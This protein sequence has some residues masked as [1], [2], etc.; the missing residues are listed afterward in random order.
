MPLARMVGTLTATINLA[1]PEL[2]RAPWPRSPPKTKQSGGAPQATTGKNRWGTLQVQPWSLAQLHRICGAQWSVPGQAK[3]WWWPLPEV[4]KDEG[5]TNKERESST[6]SF[7][8]DKKIKLVL[9]Y[10]AYMWGKNRE[11]TLG[12]QKPTPI[13]SKQYGRKMVNV[14]S[15]NV[16]HCKYP[17]P[18]LNTEE[19]QI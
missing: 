1:G 17:S 13:L 16:G 18:C 2:S 6:A 3:Q 9:S 11:K 12:F 15:Y 19:G 4:R 7:V 8:G 10:G 5:K 14:F